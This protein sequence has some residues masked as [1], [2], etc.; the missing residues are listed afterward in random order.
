MW[1]FKKSNP[2]LLSE[3]DADD[4]SKTG[5]LSQNLRARED[6]RTLRLHAGF[7]LVHAVIAMI[8][9]SS[10]WTFAPICRQVPQLLRPLELREWLPSQIHV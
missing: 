4:E 6:N 7:V 3:D 2:Y 8:W 10:F 9:L 5:F 1:S